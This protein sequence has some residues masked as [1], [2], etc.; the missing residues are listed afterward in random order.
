M[1]LVSAVSACVCACVG[2][3]ACILAVVL[4]H[5]TVSVAATAAAANKRTSNTTI[6]HMFFSKSKVLFKLFFEGTS[7]ARSP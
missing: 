6:L 3:F 1:L 7:I 2:L 5:L 4:T